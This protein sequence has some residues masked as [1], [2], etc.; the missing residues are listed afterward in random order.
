[1]ILACSP[2]SDESARA[3]GPYL[4]QKP[5]GITPELFGPGL[6]SS[7]KNELNLAYAPDHTELIFTE[8]INGRNTLV[9]VKQRNSIW[10][11][12]TIAPFSGRY[13]DVDPVFTRDGKRLY[14]SS[15]RPISGDGEAKDSDL[16]YVEKTRDEWGEPQHLSALS[17][18]GKDDYYTSITGDGT[19]YYSIFEHHD[20][21]G[22]LYRAVPDSG[23][24][25]VSE[26]LPDP[27]STGASEH[28]PFV[29]PDESYL[30]FTSDRPG[31]LGRGDLYI[32]FGNEDG[33]WTTPVNMGEEI[34]T[35]AYEYCPML[36][37]DGK[38]L[39][40]TRNAGGN[41][42]IYWVDSQIIERYRQVIVDGND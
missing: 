28:D 14:F 19:L 37:P 39:F 40:F 16:W 42:D 32:T 24:Y 33:S 7:D 3:S 34:N 25:S 36:S 27:I 11:E 9:I 5:P 6:V 18:I 1:M 15:S 23:T 31:G 13:S 21:G 26:L 4:G 30:V 17:A 20:A 29:A 38:Y 35:E 2:Q 10:G 41:G 22:D 8:R 12:R